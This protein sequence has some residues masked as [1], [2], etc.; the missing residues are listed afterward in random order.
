MLSP[1]NHCIFLLKITSC[2][3]FLRPSHNVGEQGIGAQVQKKPACV[4]LS[5]LAELEGGMDDTLYTSVM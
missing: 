3:L 4:L 5:R 2:L 1:N